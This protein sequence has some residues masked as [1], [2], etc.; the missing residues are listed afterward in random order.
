LGLV[1]GR[2]LSKGVAVGHS[3]PVWGDQ[4]LGGLLI[5][6]CLSRLCVG[7]WLLYEG[8][9]AFW[10]SALLYRLLPGVRGAGGAGSWLG[11][12]SGAGLLCSAFILRTFGDGP[13]MIA[14]LD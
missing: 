8:L 4:G 6:G 12:V 13:G 7:V 5:G 14:S 1:P 10:G 11:P 9:V 3:C 2:G